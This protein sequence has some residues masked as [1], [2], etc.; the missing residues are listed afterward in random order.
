MLTTVET[1]LNATN[2]SAYD[3]YRPEVLPYLTS[4]EF[5]S[6]ALSLSS[7]KPLPVDKS[8]KLDKLVPIE[9][10]ITLEGQGI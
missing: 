8:E 2:K 5:F 3:I 10:D 6:S 9:Q 7:R 4:C 1:W